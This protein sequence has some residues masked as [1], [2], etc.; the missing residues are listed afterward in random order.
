MKNKNKKG[1]W[2]DRQQTIRGAKNQKKS[3]Y[4]KK[5]NKKLQ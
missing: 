2:K 3:A 1:K 5:E 4:T